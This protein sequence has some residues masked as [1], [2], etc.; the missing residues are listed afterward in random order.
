MNVSRLAVLLF[1]VAVVASHA[2]ETNLTLTVD[3]ITYSN[4]TFRTVT[5]ATVNIFHKTGVATIP[6]E[7][8][9]LELQKRFGYDPQKAAGY[10]RAET[11][12]AAEIQAAQNRGRIGETRAQI[13]AR[14]GTPLKNTDDGSCVF[15]KG[16][17][18]IVVSFYQ[19]TADLIIYGKAEQ[20]ALDNSVEMSD[21]EI[22]TLLKACGGEKK[23][24]PREVI[25]VDKQWLTEDETLFA[26]YDSFKHFLAVGS[27]EYAE[28]S[29]SGKKSEEDKNLQGF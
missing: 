19:D 6:L 4:V 25:S 28:R 13:E 1:A 17:F 5:P 15:L 9:P 12:R 16:G 2:D 23:W 26:V 11:E 3:G 27:K 24:K 8:L 29:S 20:D 22:Q 10:R 7:K 18:R 14:Y 21:N